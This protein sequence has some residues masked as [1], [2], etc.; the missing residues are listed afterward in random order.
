[1]KTTNIIEDRRTSEVAMFWPAT[2]RFR[3]RRGCRLASTLLS[4]WLL[5]GV[6]SGTQYT[7]KLKNGWITKCHIL[8]CPFSFFLYL[9]EKRIVQ[10]NCKKFEIHKKNLSKRFLVFC[11]YLKPFLTHKNF[12]DTYLKR[13]LRLM[14]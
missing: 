12:V 6:W 9:L 11:M 1:M 14:K 3:I 10:K 4:T 5:A 13:L 7:D 8:S 2:R